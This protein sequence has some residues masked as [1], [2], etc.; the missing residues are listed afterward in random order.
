M[1][2]ENTI[3]IKV[4]MNGGPWSC[5]VLNLDSCTWWPQEGKLEA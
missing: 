5:A 3:L 1:T 4:Q 2:P